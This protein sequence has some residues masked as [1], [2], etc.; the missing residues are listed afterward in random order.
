MPRTS[1][2]AMSVGRPILTTDVPGC[3]ETVNPGVNGWLV[4]KGSVNELAEKMIWFI[5]NPKKIK[6][7]GKESYLIA[8]E[9][10]DVEKVNK[11]II[12]TL[13]I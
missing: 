9:K 1:L 5:E 8:K 4:N 7:F 13:N 2:E 12:N 6:I 10:F 3:R 11:Y